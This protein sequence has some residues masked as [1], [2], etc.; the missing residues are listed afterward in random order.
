MT[1]PDLRYWKS[2]H[3]CLLLLLHRLTHSFVTKRL[4]IVE[5]HT[6]SIQELCHQSTRHSREQPSSDS[7]SD[8]RLL[9]LVGFLFF[10]FHRRLL[11]RLFLFLRLPATISELC[12]W[13]DRYAGQVVQRLASSLPLA[14]TLPL[15][16]SLPLFLFRLCSLLLRLCRFLFLLFLSVSSAS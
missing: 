10:R 1:N 14:V 2:G 3:I 9:L 11:F 5:S 7:P 6:T 8:L 16:R 13:V 4:D 12:H 15:S